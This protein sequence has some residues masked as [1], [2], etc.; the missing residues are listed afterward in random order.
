MASRSYFHMYG[1][2]LGCYGRGVRKIFV[3][4]LVFIIQHPTQDVSNLSNN[5]FSST[6]LIHQM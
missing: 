2:F 4:L 3:V 1:K 6:P 5:I